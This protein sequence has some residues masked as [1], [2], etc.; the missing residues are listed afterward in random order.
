M[1]GPGDPFD[2]IADA[3]DH[4]RWD[5]PPAPFDAAILATVSRFAA[6]A[7]DTPAL[8]LGSGSGREAL[9]FVRAGRRVIL[10]DVSARM[11]SLARARYGDCPGIDYRRQSATEFL[12]GDDGQYPFVSAIGELLGYVRDRAD[13]LSG[14]RARL[15]DTGVCVFTWVDARRLARRGLPTEVR[16]DGTVIFTERDEPPLRISGWSQAHMRALIEVA[17]LDLVE[18][19]A[20]ESASPRR[21]WVVTPSKRR[22]PRSG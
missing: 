14:I 16:T 11:L 15:S 13:L 20:P 9:A 22:R 6:D 18:E 10:I 5:R 12:D 4:A 3:H 2:V 7:G 21:G 19:V 17:G 1:T 8:F